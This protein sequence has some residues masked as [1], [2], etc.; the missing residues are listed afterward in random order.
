MSF[1]TNIYHKASK[2]INTLFDKFSRNNYFFTT[3]FTTIFKNIYFIMTNIE[4][5]KY[6]SKA[7]IVVFYEHLKKIKN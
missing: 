7:Y 4:K 3:V 5:Y 1:D 6:L 2:I